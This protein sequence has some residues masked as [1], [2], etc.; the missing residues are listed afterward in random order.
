MLPRFACARS[1]GV[2]MV[3]GGG[4]GRTHCASLNVWRS[5]LRPKGEVLVWNNYEEGEVVCGV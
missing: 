5:G 2:G 1:Q 3:R 4:L